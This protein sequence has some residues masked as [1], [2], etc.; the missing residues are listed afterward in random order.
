MI[1]LNDIDPLR[2]HYIKLGKALRDAGCPGEDFHR[3]EQIYL[4]ARKSEILKYAARKT[5]AITDY[6]LE[7]HGDLVPDGIV[8]DKY[9]MGRA[10]YDAIN[11]AIDAAR[12]AMGD[13][14]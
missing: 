12:E 2:D 6:T 13:E 3:L 7:E 9:V 5:L 8:P 11:E 10:A 14:L 1:G 4:Q